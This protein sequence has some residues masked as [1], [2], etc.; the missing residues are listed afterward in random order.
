MQLFV[1]CPDGK[2]RIVNRAPSD[3]AGEIITELAERLG[4]ESSRYFL[5][6]G[7]KPI[8]CGHSIEFYSI[9]KDATLQLYVRWRDPK[10]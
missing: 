4:G 2:I 8:R 10:T 6:Y 3:D 5:L 9:P 1:V 7:G